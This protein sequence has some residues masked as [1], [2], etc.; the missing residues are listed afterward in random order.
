M[1]ASSASEEGRGSAERRRRWWSCLRV[2][3]EEVGIVWDGEGKRDFVDQEGLERRVV[4]SA[5]LSRV[6]GGEEGL[7]EGL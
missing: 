5:G 1:F 4:K 2:M 7:E 3:F 6:G